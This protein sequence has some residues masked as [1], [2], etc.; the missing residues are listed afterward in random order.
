MPNGE[1]LVY[2]YRYGDIKKESKGFEKITYNPFTDST[3]LEDV[4][5]LFDEREVLVNAKGFNGKEFVPEKI[6]TY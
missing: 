2:A 6:M 4:E 5:Y 3:K 1:A